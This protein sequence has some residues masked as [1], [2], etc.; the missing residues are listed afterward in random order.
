MKN[1]DQGCQT[2]FLL[3]TAQISKLLIWL[4]FDL[5]CVH[6]LLIWFEIKILFLKFVKYNLY[7]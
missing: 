7:T 5:I 1:L 3:S 6:K 2:Y 4:E